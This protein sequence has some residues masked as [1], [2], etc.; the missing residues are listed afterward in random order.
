MIRADSRRLERETESR[1]YHRGGRDTTQGQK[2][3]DVG[4]IRSRSKNFR[5]LGHANENG[6]AEITQS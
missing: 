3:K 5:T 4:K 1:V 6:K 2:E